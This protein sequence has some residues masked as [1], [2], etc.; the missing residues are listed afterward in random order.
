VTVEKPRFLAFLNRILL[1]SLA[2]L[3]KKTKTGPFRQSRK[4]DRI[5]L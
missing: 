2:L 3:L 5:D 1:I 4:I